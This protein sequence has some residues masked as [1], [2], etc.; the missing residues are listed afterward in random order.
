MPL[1]VSL[2]LGGSGEG[3][4]GED[5]LLPLSLPAQFIISGCLSIGAEKSPTECAVSVPRVVSVPGGGECH[6][7]GP[8]VAPFAEE[9]ER[10]VGGSSQTRVKPVGTK[11]GVLLET[12]NGKEGRKH[13]QRQPGT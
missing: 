12:R 5:S 8:H 9:G 10:Q 7:G 6:R 2:M 4:L 3:G 1:G 13:P 11:P